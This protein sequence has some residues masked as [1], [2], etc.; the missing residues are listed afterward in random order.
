MNYEKNLL[1]IVVSLSLISC[2]NRN[3]FGQVRPNKIRFSIKNCIDENV[4][5]KVDT[6][7]IY[8]AEFKR[9]DNSEK[10]INGYKFYSDNRVAFFVNINPNNVTE[11]NPKKAKM[12]YYSTCS[13]K[14]KIQIALYHV[15]SDVYISKRKFEIKNDSL[16]VTTLESPQSVFVV[17]TYLKKKLAPNELIYKPD[18]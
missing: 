3:Y 15:Q 16:I 2:V 8:L 4:F 5:K 13:E 14:N 10:Y 18:W 17:D 11:L 12:G 7:A 6:S 9:S 1:L